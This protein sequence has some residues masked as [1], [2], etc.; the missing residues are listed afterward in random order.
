MSHRF[1]TELEPSLRRPPALLPGLL[2]ILAA[3]LSCPRNH[4]DPARPR[5]EN[6]FLIVSDG[7]R[8]QEIFNGAEERLLNKA[9]GGIKDKETN[10]VRQSFWRDSAESRRAA[11]M[12]FLWSTVA[13][14]GQ[15][16]GNQKRGSVVTVSNGLKFSYPGYNEMITGRPDRR[17][18]SNDRR[19]NPNTN[20]FEWLNAR[21]RWH[22]RVSV[23][24]TW[25]VFPYIFNVHRAELP[26]WPAWESVFNSRAIPVPALLTTLQ[27]ETTRDWD[28]MTYDAFLFA[29]VTHHVR[30]ARPRVVFVGYGETD[31][32]A[33]AGRY[34]LYLEAIHQFDSY[35]RR[36]WQLTQ[37]LKEYRG[38]TTFLLVADH[39]RGGGT[40]DW[41]HHGEKVEGAEGDWIAALGPDTPSRGE[42]THVPA[43]TLGQV[44]PT[45]AALLGED[46]RRSEPAAAEPIRALLGP[47]SW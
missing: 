19:P 26:V 34:D 12:P 25:A 17:I 35:V 37:S 9:D 42:R 13:Q 1:A 22:G 16:F 4:A 41:K 15:L 29:A 3:L 27:D 20:V 39:G 36:L 44:A 6:V 45:V 32:W 21:P 23:L 5:T 28:D 24:G 30:Q 38:K 11:L 47:D 33:H 14:Q 40:E 18:D 43:V 46:F 10:R 8:W 7:L 31:E 2:L